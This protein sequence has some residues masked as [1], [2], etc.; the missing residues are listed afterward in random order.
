MEDE[1]EPVSYEGVAN[2]TPVLS[3]SGRQFGTLERVLEVPEE[4]LFDGVIVTTEQGPR[5]VDRDQI[6]EITTKYIKCNLDDDAAA[7]LPVPDGAPVY[8]ADP[9]Q[10]EGGSFKDWVG[11]KFGRGKWTEEK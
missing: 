3:S 2:G 6:A 5:F 8:K 1:A 7:N 4:D 11:R 9:L 10:D